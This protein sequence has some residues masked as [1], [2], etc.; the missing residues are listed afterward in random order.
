[1]GRPKFSCAEVPTLLHIKT[2]WQGGDAR[3]L[4]TK[5]PGILQDDFCATVVLLQFAANFDLSAFQLPHISNLLQI[6]AKMTTE[7]GHSR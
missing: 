5:L 3:C 2:L 4:S 6:N 7:N 1:M